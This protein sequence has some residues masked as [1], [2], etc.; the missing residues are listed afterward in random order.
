MFSESGLLNA[1]KNSYPH[2]TLGF[3]SEVCQH[4]NKVHAQ[5]LHQPVWATLSW[6]RP[7]IR[8]R[9]SLHCF[10]CG[11]SCLGSRNA[12]PLLQCILTEMFIKIKPQSWTLQNV[13][14]S[15][16]DVKSIGQ[17]PGFERAVGP[18]GE[19][20]V[21]RDDVDLHDAGP[22]VSEY[23]LLSVFIF[24][25]MNQAMACQSPNLGEKRVKTQRVSR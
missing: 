23:G 15:V 3:G 5:S 16:G 8:H 4:G 22:E 18:A 2:T 9:D 6:G 25:W 24:E 11:N 19:D 13:E 20:A 7:H 17:N 10:R 21:A 12:Y 14:N 1:V